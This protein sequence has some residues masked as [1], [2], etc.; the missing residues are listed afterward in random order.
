[1]AETIKRHR[2][3]RLQIRSI[4]RLR[5]ILPPCILVT[6]HADNLRQY[7]IDFYEALRRNSAICELLDFAPDKRLTHAF[8]VFYP[9]L[10][11]SQEAINAIVQFFHA[12]WLFGLIE[13]L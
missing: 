4:Q 6:S 10:D 13:N 11:E 3:C 2:F 1:M 5:Q 7:T 9:A 8:S 12:H